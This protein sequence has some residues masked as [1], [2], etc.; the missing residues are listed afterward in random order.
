[1]ASCIM[2]QKTGLVFG[3]SWPKTANTTSAIQP[4]IPICHAAAAVG[5][6]DPD[7]LPARLP[8]RRR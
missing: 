2:N 7:G 6:R 1:M 5:G 3:S 8:L 4:S